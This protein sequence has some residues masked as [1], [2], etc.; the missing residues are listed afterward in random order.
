MPYKDPEKAREYARLR[1][2]RKRRAAG[3]LPKGHFTL[4][5]R[6]ANRLAKER[7][8]LADPVARERKN[9]NN[10]KWMERYRREKGIAIAMRYSSEQERIEGQRKVLQKARKNN[11]DSYTRS[12]VVCNLVNNYGIDR[13]SIPEELIEAQIAVINIKRKV[14][15]M[16]V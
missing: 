12:Y 13:S 10:R 8:R 6:K 2:E 5:E 11:P 14:R 7:I 4:E 1:A 9:E 15:E 3:I 16:T